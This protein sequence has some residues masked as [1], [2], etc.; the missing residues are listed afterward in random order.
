MSKKRK[1]GCNG[2][3]RGSR[4]APPEREQT[5]TGLRLQE[6]EIYYEWRDVQ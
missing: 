2:C 1:G 5:L 3:H 6:V 4:F